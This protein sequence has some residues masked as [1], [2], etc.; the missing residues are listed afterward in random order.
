MG[1]LLHPLYLRAVLRRELHLHLPRRDLV[2][3]LA[4]PLPLVDDLA[5]AAAAGARTV[6]VAAVDRA[7]DHPDA[8]LAYLETERREDGVGGAGAFTP[9]ARMQFR[10]PASR[11]GAPADPRCMFCHLR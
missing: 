5:G 4:H 1:S 10:V 8:A 11:R 3:V 2:L 6:R 7:A 9:G